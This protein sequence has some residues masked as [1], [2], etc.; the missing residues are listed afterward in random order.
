MQRPNYLSSLDPIKFANRATPISSQSSHFDSTVTPF[1][2]GIRIEDFNQPRKLW[3]KVRHCS[4]VARLTLQVFSAE[5]RERAIKNIADY[6]ATS[7]HP[8]SIKQM[9]GIFSYVSTELSDGI[10]KRLNVKDYPKDLS[11]V[12]FLGSHNLLDLKNPVKARPRA[13]LTLR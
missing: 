5:G 4:R 2:S 7:R 12:A 13:F 10:A 1:L 3:E 8:E 9:L 11:K 6:M